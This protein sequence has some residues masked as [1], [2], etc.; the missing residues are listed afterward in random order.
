MLGFLGKIFGSK[1]KE[2]HLYHRVVVHI[3]HQIDD[4]ESQGHNVIINEIVLAYFA[5]VIMSISRKALDFKSL[6][7][8]VRDLFFL[9]KYKILIDN[10]FAIASSCSD[11]FREKCIA[12]TPLVTD[13]LIANKGSY[14]FKYTIWANKEIEAMFEQDARDYDPRTAN[15]YDFLDASR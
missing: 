12:L 7:F 10:A 9:P 4:L 3:R 15:K 5:V 2:Q 6:E 1:K 14:L 11:D 13:E 8:Y